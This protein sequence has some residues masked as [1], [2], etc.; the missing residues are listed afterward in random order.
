MTGYLLGHICSFPLIQHV[1]DPSNAAK[2]T[3]H[4]LT[5]FGHSNST[6]ISDYN[7]KLVTNQLGRS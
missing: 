6:W 4:F 1:D 2:N 7:P 3:E 5:S